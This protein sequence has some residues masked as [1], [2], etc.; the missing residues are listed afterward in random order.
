M[1]RERVMKTGEFENL[2]G[3]WLDEPQRADLAARIDAAVA[4][5]PALARER[6]RLT[7]LHRLVAQSLSGAPRIDEARFVQ[8]ISAAI[9]HDVENTLL[10]ADTNRL[11]TALA[12]IEHAIDWPRVS[13]RIGDAID[14]TDARVRSS[15]R[16]RLASFALTAAAAAVALFF[17]R[18]QPIAM[19]RPLGHATASLVATAINHG[20]IARVVLA[21]PEQQDSSGAAASPVVAAEFFLMIE[22]PARGGA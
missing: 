2:I 3:E 21:P 20:G 13:E 11:I 8:R 4:A 19:D 14:Q 10:D 15:R 16:L 12:P 22:P 17:L 18:P 6:E 1:R 5:D 7:R 9:D